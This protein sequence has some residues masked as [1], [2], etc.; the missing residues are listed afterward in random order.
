MNPTIETKVVRLISKLLDHCISP[1]EHKEL[2]QLMESDK[3]AREVYVK[4]MSQEAILSHAMGRIKTTIPNNHPI[5]FRIL[6]SRVFAVAA[7]LL[8]GFSLA[9]LLRSELQ[10]PTHEKTFPVAFI[11]TSSDARPILFHSGSHSIKKGSYILDFFSGAQV[12]ITAPAKFNI[13]SSMHLHLEKGQ[14]VANVNPAAHLFKITSEG[15]SFVDLGTEFSLNVD[16]GGKSDLLVFEGEVVANTINDNGATEQVEIVSQN[17][18]LHYNHVHNRFD[19]LEAIQENFLRHEVS[20]SSPIPHLQAYQQQVKS[21]KPAHYWDFD[22]EL[23]DS[24]IDSIA[25]LVLQAKGNHIETTSN[26]GNSAIYFSKDSQFH[27]LTLK[28]LIEFR[29]NQAF[30]IEFLFC[31]DRIN[32]ASIF[33]LFDPDSVTSNG[34]ANHFVLIETMAEN[35]WYSHIPACVRSVYRPVA[36]TKASSGINSFGK[37][38]YYPGVWTH[39]VVSFDGRYLR[40]YQNSRLQNEVL[41]E[42]NEQ[43]NEFNQYAMVLGQM[44][45]Y[46]DAEPPFENYRPFMGLIDELAL[47]DRVLTADE[48]KSHVRELPGN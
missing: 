10:F 6:K 42:E 20:R 8:L 48:I 29:K 28:G 3:E 34:S 5:L 40:T 21:S 12:R 22:V 13:L 36:D 30:S 2:A 32:R 27:E 45:S 15:N 19:K 41:I 44:A 14:L 24:H 35:D 39:L 38:H 9:W 31:A 4:V 43:F 33:S 26:E 37:D 17:E 18:A 1:K 25:G 23:D 47:Y 16:E 7:A 11:R 46:P